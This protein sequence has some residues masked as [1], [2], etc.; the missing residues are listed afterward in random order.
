MMCYYISSH[1]FEILSIYANSTT[2]MH[3]SCTP[4]PKMTDRDI[5]ETKR[6]IRDP[7][8]SKRQDFRTSEEEKREREIQ[9]KFLKRIL[10]T[11]NL[12]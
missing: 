8:V 3:F 2:R 9:N 5:L 7:L 12:Q 4:V 6:A 11:K 1:F 10:S